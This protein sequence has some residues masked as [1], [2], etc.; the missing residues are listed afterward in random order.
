MLQVHLAKNYFINRCY[1]Q[2]LCKKLVLKKFTKLIGEAS[3]MEP[4]NKV[5]SID[6]KLC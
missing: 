3:A 5:K 1:E 2:R 6:L 4:F